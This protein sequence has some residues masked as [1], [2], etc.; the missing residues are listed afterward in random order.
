MLKKSL[1][2]LAIAAASSSVMAADITGTAVQTVSAEGN[3]VHTVLTSADVSVVLAAEYTVGDVVTFTFDGAELDVDSVPNSIVVAAT[4]NTGTSPKDYYGMTLGQ[5]S[6]SK[7]HVTYR[8][9]ELTTVASSTRPHTTINQVIKLGDAAAVPTA[10]LKFNAK[11]LASKATVT[12]SAVTGNNQAL[13]TG[14]KNVTDLFA[15]KSQFK[16]NVDDAGKAFNAVIN[17]NEQRVQ[18]VAVGSNPAD[19]VDVLDLKLTDSNSAWLNAATVNTVSYTV[20]GNFAFL[21]SD[22]ETEGVQTLDDVVTFSGSPSKVT[23]NADSIVAEYATAQLTT[24]LTLDLA[25]SASSDPVSK[26]VIPTQDFTATVSAKYTANSIATTKDIN[27]KFNAGEWTLNGA[28]VHVPFM[29]F[30]DGYAPIVNVSNTSTQDGDI[31]VVVYAADNAWVA[32][33]SYMLSV[34]AKAQAQT[35]ITAAL[36]NAGI[37]G[38]VAFDIIVNAPKDDIEVSALYFNAGDRAVMNTTKK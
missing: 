18:F 10:P 31:E 14:T 11:T 33:K 17:V 16:A 21:D 3:A 6:K 38:D 22:P 1:I 24:K 15:V 2:A 26:V 28:L 27:T 23:V 19:V 30:R 35:N 25:G 37:K 8:V 29:P 7:N 36:R 34:P 32:P 9:T 4:D 13:D 12:Y 20:Y 5:L